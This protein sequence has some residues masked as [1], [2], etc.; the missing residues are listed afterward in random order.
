MG[1]AK[2]NINK[3]LIMTGQTE[4]ELFAGEQAFGTDFILNLVSQALKEQ[5]KIVWKD[6]PNTGL[7]A[8]SYSL[9]PL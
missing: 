3:Y 7:D 6:E 8:M 2:E 1:A 9:Q 4:Q 5:K